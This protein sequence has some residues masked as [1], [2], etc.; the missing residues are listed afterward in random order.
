M[1]TEKPE[2]AKRG[3][4]FDFFERLELARVAFEHYRNSVNDLK[5]ESVGFADEFVLRLS[6]EQRSF[7]DRAHE[8][9]K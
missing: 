6:K 9:V 2:E 3:G 8:Y 5:S 7:A 4:L 1:T